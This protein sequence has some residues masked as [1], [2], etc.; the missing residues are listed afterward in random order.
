[1][2]AL[3]LNPARHS[4]IQHRVPR[5]NGAN[6][7]QSSSFLR[8]ILIFV[9]GLSV[10][11]GF[12]IYQFHSYLPMVDRILDRDFKIKPYVSA[13]KSKSPGQPEHVP[14][15]EIPAAPVP[16]LK[17]AVGGS[18][19]LRGG[20][21]DLKGVKRNVPGNNKHP[22]PPLPP[23]PYSVNTTVGDRGVGIGV[24][25]RDDDPWIGWQGQWPVG[26]GQLVRN[27]LLFA[28]LM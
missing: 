3:Q 25:R 12:G 21:T 24:F 26:N 4:P 14:N 8:T 9:L 19:G 15:N 23:T 22:H 28:A 6:E 1:M 11:M 2:R 5:L 10:V 27:S 7:R 16:V 20:A 17:A 13:P 18:V